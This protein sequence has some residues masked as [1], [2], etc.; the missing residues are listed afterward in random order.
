[1]YLRG[2]YGMSTIERDEECQEAG[3]PWPWWK[4]LSSARLPL[5]PRSTNIRFINGQ[6]L[7]G[8]RGG[9]SSRPGTPSNQVVLGG[10]NPS[11]CADSVVTEC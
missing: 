5:E 9:L 10:E 1:M 4:T 3:V 6:H 7:L 11:F 2:Q 8:N